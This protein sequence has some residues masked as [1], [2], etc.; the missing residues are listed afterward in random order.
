[1]LLKIN[2]FLVWAYM[3]YFFRY[4][5]P[6]SILLASSETDITAVTR[7]AAALWRPSRELVQSPE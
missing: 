4:A 2:F 6:F 1:M 5:L 3:N 7:W